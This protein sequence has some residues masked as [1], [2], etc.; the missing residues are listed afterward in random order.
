MTLG[1]SAAELAAKI[2]VDAGRSRR[3]D[4]APQPLRRGGVGR[5]FRQ[6]RYRAQPVQRRSRQPPQPLP[7]PHYGDTAGGHGGLAGRACVQ[8]RPRRQRRRPGPRARTIPR[9]P[10]SMPAATTWARSWPAPIPAPERR[11]VPR[12]CSAT[13][14]RCTPPARAD[15]PDP[16]AAGTGFALGSA[17]PWKSGPARG[18]VPER[19]NGAVSKTVVRY[20]YRGF[21]S[22]P[23]RQYSNHL[24]C[25]TEN[26]TWTAYPGEGRVRA[27]GRN[28]TP[29]S[30]RCSRSASTARSAALRRAPSCCGYSFRRFRRSRPQAPG[31][32]RFRRCPTIPTNG[33]HREWEFRATSRPPAQ[34]LP[35]DGS[36]DAR[37]REDWY[38]TRPFPL[39][40]GMG[41]LQ[42]GEA[43]AV[44]RNRR[45]PV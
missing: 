42:E 24:V 4:R 29:I 39:G 30:A 28:R 20:A 44:L 1:R 25:R 19:S 15:G 5:R 3:H 17:P 22:H 13:A 36:A 11:W 43:D 40:V 6:G 34:P 37:G 7:R 12:W 8:R 14:R 26:G 18:G 32:G 16:L 33:P 45:G 10:A 27:V 38:C 9:S 23:L 35:G 2:G 31:F 21:E 41:A